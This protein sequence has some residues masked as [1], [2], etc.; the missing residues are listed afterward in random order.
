[1]SVSSNDSAELFHLM[2]TIKMKVIDCNR[3][4]MS[5]GSFRLD[6]LQLL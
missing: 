5:T 1:M 6:R 2:V 3:G 4:S